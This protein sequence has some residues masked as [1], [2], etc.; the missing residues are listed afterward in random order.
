MSEEYYYSGSGFYEDGDTL[1]E[2]TFGEMTTVPCQNPDLVKYR[3]RRYGQWW[4]LTG[5]SPLA[6][7]PAEV[8][9]ELRRRYA[10]VVTLHHPS[11]TRMVAMRDV[12]VARGECIIEEYPDGRTL[13]SFMETSP[14]AT[15][16]R[17]LMDQLLDALDYCHSKGVA[18]GNI[19]PKSIIIQGHSLT[20]IDFACVD[21]PATDIR[22]LA[23]IL[24]MLR[25]KGT[26]RIVARCRKGRYKQVNDIVRELDRKQILRRWVLPIAVGV[27]MVATAILS[28]VL[29][30]WWN[31][32]TTARRA[33]LSPLPS[34]YFSDTVNLHP[35][36]G[37]LTYYSTMTKAK[38]FYLDYTGATPGP[39][40]ESVAVDL[41]LS[42]KWAPFNVGCSDNDVNHLGG[43]YTWCDTTGY[44]IFTSPESYWPSSKPLT[45][46]SG[47]ERDPVPR[48]WGG[49]WR[50]PTH[51]E[52]KELHENC[53]WSLVNKT[54]LPLGYTV[55][56]PNGNS[57]FLPLS[58][59][60]HKYE[61]AKI[62]IEGHY[63]SS[64][65]VDG[66]SRLIYV[67]SLDTAHINYTD[68][69]EIG[70]AFSIRPVL[71]Q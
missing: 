27:A 42:V 56:A 23:P 9:E 64:T 17:D 29:G 45:E 66:R 1:I 16:R 71:G 28:F 21:D 20:L 43:F 51:E 69:V 25:P 44:G 3:A 53:V 36:A 70:P 15:L 37:M 32:T 57:I 24:E 10:V 14:S 41:G 31:Q 18:H 8:L 46:I 22:S 34:I 61:D 2:G 33:E 54:G 48:L 30:H 7:H 59:Y 58:G 55:S 63:W 39:I 35:G 47:T 11:I 19:T 38:L 60:R 52:L 68:S 6:A 65:P 12:D 26:K 13:D 49:R 40:D 67:T 5:V 62:G 50:L 4:L